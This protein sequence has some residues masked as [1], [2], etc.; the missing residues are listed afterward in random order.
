MGKTGGSPHPDLSHRILT[1][2][3][4]DRALTRNALQRMLDSRFENGVRAMKR[5]LIACLVAFGFAAPAH[6]WFKPGNPPPCDSANVVSR[7]IQRFAYADQRTFHWGVAIAQVTDIYETPEVI[8]NTSLIGRRYCRGTAWLSDGRRS[9]AVW[10]IESK[11][12]FVSIGYR[13][14]SCLP[15]YDPW[16]VYG[17]WCRSIEP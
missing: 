7:V 6:A 10:I 3:S 5:L 1:E 12:G 4:P 17:S 14:E 2:S 9:Q 13:V 8:R 15:A 11:Q 16:H